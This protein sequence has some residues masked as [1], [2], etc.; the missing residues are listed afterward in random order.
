MQLNKHGS[1][2]IRNGWPTK[3]IDS[4]EQ[5]GLIFSPNNE[6]MAVDEIGVG[7]VMIKAMRYWATVLGIT[8]EGK[9]QQ[10]VVHTL[11]RLG[12]LISQFDP[13]CQ[14]KGTLWLLH[15]NLACDIENASAWGWAFSIYSAKSFKKEEFVTAFYS[16]I[17]RNGAKYAKS[18]VDKEFDCFKN[19]Y[20]SEKAFD[21]GKIIDEDTVPFFAPLKLIT[22]I[23]DSQFEKHRTDSKEIP[24]DI[25]LYCVL[26]DNAAHLESNKQIDLDVLLDGEKQVGRYMNL[27]YSTLLDL[28]QQLE[29]AKRLKLIN[30]F[31]SRYI[32]VLDDNANELLTKYYEGIT[33]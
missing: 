14:N 21:I 8:T 30:N 22:Y 13:Y 15:R 31:G 6:L 18:A 3:I 1:F 19:T 9:S 28:L 26:S 16:Y 4:V 33:R 17:Q 29:N 32:Q 5:N 23:G 7:R 10:G 2:Y 27:S 11:T 12:M 24:I 25:L 20:V